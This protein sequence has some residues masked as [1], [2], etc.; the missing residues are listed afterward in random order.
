MFCAHAK[1]VGFVD[2]DSAQVP[3]LE[4]YQP[5]TVKS[6]VVCA[7]ELATMTHRRDCSGR[8]DDVWP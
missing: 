2:F 5:R 6:L 7:I 1:D 8:K 3:L 4:T